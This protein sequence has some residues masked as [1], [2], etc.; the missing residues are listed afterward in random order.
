MNFLLHKQVFSLTATLCSLSMCLPEVLMLLLLHSF[1]TSKNQIRVDLVDENF[2][3][4]RGEIA[5]PP[6]TPYEG[7]QPVCMVA[8][9][10]YD[11]IGSV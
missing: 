3:E 1:Q 2:T 8:H 7:E 11:D 5:G 4:L 10:P 6:D 9:V